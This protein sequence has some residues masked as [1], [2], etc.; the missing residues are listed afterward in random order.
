VRCGSGVITDRR[1]HR[2][3]TDHHPHTCRRFASKRNVKAA[4]A[5]AEEAAAALAE[6]SRTVN[7]L[8]ER[9]GAMRR[10]APGDEGLRLAL[11]EAEAARAALQGQLHNQVM[12]KR[13]RLPQRTRYF[14]L[15]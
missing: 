9:I 10:A 13:A 8:W 6:K 12:T 14:F 2:R 11:A 5:A 3:V 4:V 7:S 15:L 1:P